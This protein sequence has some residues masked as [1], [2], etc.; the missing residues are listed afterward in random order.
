MNSSDTQE[1]LKNSKLDYLFKDKSNIEEEVCTN[2]KL[3]KEELEKQSHKSISDDDLFTYQVPK[4]VGG[5]CSIDFGLEPYDLRYDMGNEAESHTEFLKLL[6]ILVRYCSSKI[7]VEWLG[8]YKKYDHSL[9]K[10]S[11]K[12]IE[13]RPVFPLN[14]AEFLSN[15]V[16]VANSGIGIVINDI[17]LHIQQGKPYYKCDAKVKS[18][19]CLPI[20]K[21]DGQVWG[22][23]DAEDHRVGFFDQETII[24]LISLCV[25]ISQLANKP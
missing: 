24:E 8:V 5:Y 16:V 15:N 25:F 2:I 6:R 22:I 21:E 1:Y 14:D 4:T 12:G 9:V 3:Y 19:T 7:N 11:Y 10:L 23:I 20:C 18:E 13:S 17:N